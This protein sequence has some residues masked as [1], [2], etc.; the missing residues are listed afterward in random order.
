MQ[1]LLLEL[2]EVNFDHLRFYAGRGSLPNLDALMKRHG[3]AE[4][5]SETDYEELEPWIQWVTAH[6][7]L[8]FARH[9]VFRLGD[10]ESRDILQIWEVLEASGVRVGAMSPMNAK[11]RTRD[12]AFFVPDPWTS[13]RLTAT[14][15][16]MRLYE[17]IRQA[18][19]DNA[20]ARLSARSIL[21][22][23]LAAMRYCRPQNYGW[24]LSL[25]VAARTKPWVR[26]MFLDL[27]LADVF[28]HEV[29]NKRP[30]F[31]SLFL[32]SAAHIQHHYMFNSTAYAGQRENPRWYIEPS[33][34]PVADVYRLYDRIVGLVRQA[35][36]NARLMIATGLHQDPHPELTFYWRLKDH[37]AYLRKLNV[38]FVRV[39][40]RMSRDFIVECASEA[41]ARR[42]EE[43]L[44]SAQTETGGRLF[45]V[46]NRGCDVFAMLTWPHDI[47][48]DFEYRVEGV[49][50][51][52]FRQ[53]VA[54][55]AIKNGQHNGIGYFIDSGVVGAQVP[56]SFP[57][58]DLPRRIC[59][60]LGVEWPA[61][62]SEGSARR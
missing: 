34:D 41:D 43:L 5:T 2:N 29:G 55:V 45:E 50:M 22:L 54:F 32:N 56:T 42:A 28:V 44:R 58:A 21:W 46:D 3:V 33:E 14:P 9:G 36:P 6:T 31:A 40:A 20:Q 48:E 57:L 52:G 4:T 30:Q 7:G 25:A 26:S 1:V 11:N 24:Y 8:P 17:A 61:A 15:L 62:V 19:N 59:A 60:A 38:P 13:T 27:V 10:I 23:I 51:A 47:G 12:A 37:A 16:L 39:A 18:V 35:F 49:R 53:D